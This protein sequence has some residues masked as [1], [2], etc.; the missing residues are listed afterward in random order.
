MTERPGPASL[1]GLGGFV[2]GRAAMPEGKGATA[3][4]ILAGRHPAPASALPMWHP[5]T[6]APRRAQ[7]RAAGQAVPGDETARLGLQDGLS[8]NPK[9]AVLQCVG[10]QA[11]GRGGCRRLPCGGGKYAACGK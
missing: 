6:S 4:L 11:V 2:R 10:S 1:R 3:I 7:G 8:C 9:R 5:D